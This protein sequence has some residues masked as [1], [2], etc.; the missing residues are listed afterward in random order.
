MEEINQGQIVVLPG[1]SFA[2]STGMIRRLLI[3]SM[4]LAAWLHA[5]EQPV[6]FVDVTVVP[7][8]QGTDFA[9]SN[10]SSRGQANHPRWR[11][12]ATTGSWTTAPPPPIFADPAL[13]LLP[14]GAV[15]LHAVRRLGISR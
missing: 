14:N 4:T 1:A 9:S 8:G 7:D 3:V 5:H 11:Y 2:A 12:N 15:S 10:G 13:A 6:A